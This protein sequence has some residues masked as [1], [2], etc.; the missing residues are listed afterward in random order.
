MTNQKSVSAQLQK[1]IELF[2]SEKIPE[3]IALSVNPR[4]ETPSQKWSFMNRII[5]YGHQTEDARGFQQWRNAGRTV[6]KGAKSIPI[7]APITK[8]QKTDKEDK[9]EE[10][11][12]SVIGF[13]KI[14]VFRVEDTKG[15]ALE[16][17]KIEMPDLPLVEV[18]DKW[19][20]SIKNCG[21]N[22]IFH[23][24]YT[25]GK[26]LIELC[27]PEENV[28]FHELVHAAHGKIE[29]P[30]CVAEWKREIIAELGACVLSY[31]VGKSPV[32]VGQHYN[33]I[34]LYAKEVG[35]EPA[36]AC[37]DVINDTEK[38]LNLILKDKN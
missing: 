10:K 1:I 5:M 38:I 26:D 2:E 9:K 29:N 17:E 13:R 3:A 14:P 11:K 33:Y 6:K 19:G 32:N 24:R 20:I 36:H 7:I 37:I 31:L 30:V 22:G 15:E 35:K 28:F 12:G 27:S 8:K 18:A 23:G 21:S 34:A 4:I 16:Y 25:H